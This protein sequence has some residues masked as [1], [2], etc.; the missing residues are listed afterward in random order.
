MTS[1]DQAPTS[2]WS[3]ARGWAISGGLLALA[4]LWDLSGWDLQVMQWFGSEQGFA[5]RNNWWLS[6]VM[7]TRAQQLADV[8]YV[9]LLAMVFWPLGPF[10]SVSRR[11]RVAALVAITASVLAVSILKRISLTSCPWD[12]SLFGGTASYIS[13][14]HLGVRDGGHGHCFPSGHASSALSFL[15]LSF[16]ALF[17]PDPARQGQG[18]ALLLLVGVLGLVFGL[19]QTVRGAHYPSHTLWTAWV[20]WTVGWLVYRGAAGQP[21]R[22]A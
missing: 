21:D 1:A 2:P 22:P 20:C 9:F 15:A 10:K 3:R 6:T 12:L 16:P 17:S 5:L 4:L 8:T 19:T 11:Q 18:R 14:W 7:H 13:H